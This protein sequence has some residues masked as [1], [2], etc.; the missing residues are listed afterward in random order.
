LKDQEAILWLLNLQLQRQHCSRLPRAFSVRKSIFLFLKRD[1]LFVVNFYSAGVVNHN[2][3][4]GYKSQPFDLSYN[5]G[6]LRIY[7]TTSTLMRS[8]IF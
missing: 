2:R 3:R 5:I 1:V 4:I 7:N 8:S 6:A